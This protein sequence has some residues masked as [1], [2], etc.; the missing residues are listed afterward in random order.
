[1]YIVYIKYS[2]M[3]AKIYQI[4]NALLYLVCLLFFLTGCNSKLDYTIETT[5]NPNQIAPLTAMLNI[6][7]EVP[8]QATIKVLGDIP[9]EQSFKES[10][11]NLNIP[12]LGLY[13]NKLNKVEVTL[14]YDGGKQV[15]IIEIQT[16]EVPNFFPEIGINKMEKE[17]ME[18]GMH[19]LDI[20]F[21][22]F[23]KFRSAPII[24]DDNGQIRWYLDLSFHKAMVG[25]FQ[26]IKNG[27]I[28]VAGR[29]TIYEFDMIGKLLV[30]TKINSNYGIHHDVLELPNE[31]LL[32]CVGKR[33]GYIE[34]DGKTILSDN[35]FMIHFDRRQSKIIKEWD[36][37]KH[38][39]VDRDVAID[40]AQRVFGDGDWLHM[41]SLDFNGRDS[42][43]IVS[44][45]NQGL[46]KVTWDDK[47]KWIMAPKQK[48][49]K[50]GRKG[51]GY[52][53]KPYLLTAINKEGEPYN[54]DIQNGITSAKDFDFP[55]G[56]HAPYLLPNGNLIVFDNGPFRNYNNETQYSRA[57]E[58][59]VDE[60]NK[61][62][63][64]V[65]EYGKDRG[66]NLFSPIVSDVDLLP[67]T[68]N[69]LV[70]SGFISPRN[71]HR[72]KIVE[73]SPENNKEVFEATI[74]FKNTNRDINNPGWGQADVLYRSE[75]MELKF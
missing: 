9:V 29:N 17:K 1:M 37:A 63:K 71:V 19:A 44:G 35:D 45:R 53:T 47:L 36:L 65:W 34:K 15:E 3:S 4:K 74:F 16:S 59:Q 50:S 72:A 27:N 68:K 5:L 28:L 67:Y 66:F 39:D 43:I 25:P 58:Y 31:D 57:V 40:K 12:V 7:S 42:T 32:I 75:R 22:N 2:N 11:T 51:R 64:Q 62:F 54:K 55:W 60:K 70:T 69:I 23:G 56:P 41:N 73:V 8:C 46:I 38:L 24:F 26:K 61:T 48:W 14:N 21:A 33:D 10:S 49:G 6:T 30:M 13:A 18:P 52:N 20:H